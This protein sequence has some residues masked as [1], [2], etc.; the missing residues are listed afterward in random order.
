MKQREQQN[1]NSTV[2]KYFSWQMV[3][4]CLV[5]SSCRGGGAAQAPGKRLS[6]K[7]TQSMLYFLWKISYFFLLKNLWKIPWLIIKIFSNLVGQKKCN[8]INQIWENVN[9]RVALFLTLMIY[10]S[11]RAALKS[12]KCDD[13][14][15]QHWTCWLKRRHPYWG[16]RSK[17]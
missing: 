1:V 14:F 3:K 2:E 8:S 6:Q 17:W 10:K 4:G 15:W 16:R 9:D 13:F 5:Q 12:L 11:P 7:F